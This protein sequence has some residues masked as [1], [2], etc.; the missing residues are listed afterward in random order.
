MH[1]GR[2]IK[3]LRENYGWQQKELALK[4]EC[5]QSTISMWETEKQEPN[6]SMRRKLCKIFGITEA[7][8]FNTSS[9]IKENTA[10]QSAPVINW[11]QL[12]Q[13]IS[14][15]TPLTKDISDNHVYTSV[16]GE[17]IFA[18]KVEKD[19][20]YPEFKE[21]DM[22][23]INPAAQINPNDYIVVLD[24]KE[25]LSFLTQLKKY[26]EKTIFH[27]LNPKFPDIE[28]TDTNQYAIV[29]KVAEK[30]KKY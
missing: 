21:G 6:P 3:L 24:N 2:R 19:G 11:P 27:P 23:I 16:E 26:G 9:S 7:Q 4:L 17:N 29:G 10:T 15:K 5:P 18:L 25:N 28:L 12:S 1:L 22:I 20:M 30:I 8:L 13:L 14:S